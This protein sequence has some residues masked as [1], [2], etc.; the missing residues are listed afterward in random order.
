MEYKCIVCGKKPEYRKSY[1]ANC[2][3]K[4][5]NNLAIYEKICNEWKL[6][7]KQESSQYFYFVNEVKD[8]LEGRKNLVIGRKGEGKTAIAQ[9]V[10][11]QKE[12]NTFTEKLSFKNFPFN[13]LYEL[14]NSQYTHP[15]QYISIWKYLIYTTICKLMI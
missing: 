6:E 3:K 11:E 13:I 15:N 10:Y 8:I 5:K 7:A 9:Y 14:S 4:V 1:C 2:Y 12:Y